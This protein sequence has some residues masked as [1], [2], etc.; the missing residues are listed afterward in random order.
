L[1]LALHDG[2]VRQDRSFVK[3]PWRLPERTLGGLPL[4]EYERIAGGDARASRSDPLRLLRLSPVR[5]QALLVMLQ[6]GTPAAASVASAW[7]PA[8]SLTTRPPDG[9]DTWGRGLDPEVNLL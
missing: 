6:L 2:P 5:M 7:W 3:R 1:T 8:R 9:P 4:R